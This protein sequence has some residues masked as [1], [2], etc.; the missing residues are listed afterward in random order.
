MTLRKE[1][2]MSSIKKCLIWGTSLDKFVPQT[3]L[4]DQNPQG[5]R[6]YFKHLSNRNKYEIYNLRAGGKYLISAT[7]MKSTTG[8]NYKTV[9][10]LDSDNIPRDL[11]ESKKVRLSGYIAQE[12]LRGN[13]PDLDKLMKDD[14]PA[15]LP[16]IP[17]SSERRDLLLRGL[18]KLSSNIGDIVTLKNEDENT[19]DNPT[20]FLYALSYCSKET[21]FSHLLEELK[22]SQYVKQE[23]EYSGEIGGFVVTEKGRQKLKEI[24]NG[25]PNRDST[26][27]FIAMWFTDSEDKSHNTMNMLHQRIAQ[28]ITRAGYKPIRSDD[29]KNDDKV[30]NKI[31]SL[32]EKSKFI[33]CDIT[34]EDKDK[35][36]ASVFFEAGYAKG[37]NIPVIWSCS[38]TMKELQVKVFDTRQYECVFWDKNCMS[39]FEEEL[40]KQIEDNEKIGRGPLKGGYK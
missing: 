27:A 39:E 5:Y 16:P 23:S 25:I 2:K 13:T 38:K 32:I 22:Q 10:V 7:Q 14:W 33:V 24:E 9:R 36:R 35:P 37:K 18:V 19:S 40:Q 4:S 8:N 20:P 1:I 3:H 28:A 6:S 31:L 30:D 34:A 15:K 21:E 29:I 17:E 12:N 26:T 11:S